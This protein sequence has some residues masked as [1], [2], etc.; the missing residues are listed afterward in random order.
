MEGN[1]FS[2][3]DSFSHVSSNSSLAGLSIN[4]EDF[5]F[6]GAEELGDDGVVLVDFLDLELTFSV[7]CGCLLGLFVF[8]TS[9]S[10][11]DYKKQE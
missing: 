1:Y 4:T 8:V 7:S 5:D 11:V 9:G 3:P 6:V 2:D 10:W